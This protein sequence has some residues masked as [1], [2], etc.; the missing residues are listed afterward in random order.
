M[1][2]PERPSRQTL[3]VSP[4]QGNLPVALGA[5]VCGCLGFGLV[6]GLGIGRGRDHSTAIDAPTAAAASAEPGWHPRDRA[7]FEPLDAV[8]GDSA[9]ASRPPVADPAVAPASLDLPDPAATV[10]S[11]GLSRFSA[12][13]SAIEAP[14]PDAPPAPPERLSLPPDEEIAPVLPAASSDLTE[15][16]AVD[17]PLGDPDP[18]DSAADSS[19]AA[20]DEA[21]ADDEPAPRTLAAVDPP[22]LTD[23]AADAAP[24]PLEVGPPPVVAEPRVTEAILPEPNCGVPLDPRPA[25]ATAPTSVP[26]PS[27]AAGPTAGSTPFAAAPALVPDEPREATAVRAAPDTAAADIAGQGRPGPIQLEGIQSP[28]LTVEKRGPREVQVGKPARY[29]ILVRNVGSAVAHDVAL[30]DTVPYGAALVTTTPPAAPGRAAPGVPND[31]L[32][33][34]LGELAP[35]RSVELAAQLP[36]GMKFVRANNAGWHDERTH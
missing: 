28:Q 26:M 36:P 31:E 33:W 12:A 20:P 22:A 18:L 10:V 25:A 14:P 29:E 17:A 35:A 23:P 4:R 11:G 5:V 9:G 34:S 15:P 30:R 6:W 21:P 16:V 24:A 3:V 19:T 13:A 2:A 8:P 27:P 32:V 7:D 1:S